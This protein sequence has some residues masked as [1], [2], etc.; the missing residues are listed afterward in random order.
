MFS[1]EYFHE[2]YMNQFLKI[3]K[4]QLKQLMALKNFKSKDMEV[5]SVYNMKEIIKLNDGPSV[6]VVFLPVAEV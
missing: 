1:V 4:A 3:L 2:I 5:F 6:K